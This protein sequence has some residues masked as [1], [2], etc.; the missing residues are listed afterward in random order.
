VVKLHFIQNQ[1]LLARYNIRSFAHSKD[2]QFG[3][4]YYH[5]MDTAIS[6]T[7]DLKEHLAVKSVSGKIDSFKTALEEYR[8]K[9]EVRIQSLKTQIQVSKELEKLSQSIDL[10]AQN[11][12]KSQTDQSLVL[13]FLSM[14]VRTQKLTMFDVINDENLQE[15][16]KH[17]EKGLAQSQKANK[18]D[19][20]EIYQQYDKLLSSYVEA[21]QNSSGNFAMQTEKLGRKAT[22]LS[23]MAVIEMNDYMDKKISSFTILIIS[24]AILS[25]I[26]GALVAYYI[27]KYIVSHLF[28]GVKLAQAYSAGDF[29]Y[30]VNSSDLKLKDEIGELVN[31]MAIMGTKLREIINTVHQNVQRISSAGTQVAS[32]S[33][34]LSEEANRQASSVEEIA[35]SMEEVVSNTQLNSEN[36]K[37]T[38]SASDFTASLAKQVSEAAESSLKSVK[39]IT[40]RINVI[41]DIA[42]Q[43]NLLALNAAVEAAR[44]GENGKG[45]AVVASEVRKLA[46]N[47]KKAALEVISMTQE[48][49]QLT[50]KSVELMNQLIPE[51]EK[52]SNLVKEIT[53][54]SIEQLNGADQINNAVQQLN[55]STQNTASAA[56]ELATS[57]E[58]V[59]IQ[60]ETLL[61]TINYLKFK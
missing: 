10:I 13:N 15:I 61:E 30:E 23:E 38:Q 29:T 59:K 27:S 32:T 46:E 44:A 1:F 55:Q 35:S 12:A 25:I 19:F 51:I 56:E 37:Q 45:F 24:L 33:S 47:S 40:S 4:K 50:Q 43:T 52:A 39:L 8:N 18:K 57:S 36:S 17:I 31:A 7:I 60:S 41:N 20:L 14:H 2:E 26:L 16:Q 9:V 6:V 48:S 11:P 5:A 49:Q 58:E 34:I 28:K 3:N 22:S 42:F 54:S 21:T 53:A